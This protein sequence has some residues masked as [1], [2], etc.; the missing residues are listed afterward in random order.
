MPFVFL[1]LKSSILKNYINTKTRFKSSFKNSFANRKN[2]RTVLINPRISAH[3]DYVPEPISFIL[4]TW[5]ECSCASSARIEKPA[6]NTKTPTLTF[7]FKVN[8]QK[9][10]PWVTHSKSID[11][12]KVGKTTPPSVDLRV[13]KPTVKNDILGLLIPN[14]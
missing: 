10:Y 5:I 8:S 6:A 11:Q 9:R 7:G 1:P 3:L 12:P 2:R 13:T 4:V 14:Q